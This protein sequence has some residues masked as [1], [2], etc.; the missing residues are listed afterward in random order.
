[1]ILNLIILITGIVLLIKIFV[2]LS[3]YLLF[4]LTL[5]VYI[6]YQVFLP[7]QRENVIKVLK[8]F[9]LPV[10]I[11]FFPFVVIF[12]MRDKHPKYALWGSLLWSLTYLIFAIDIMA[13]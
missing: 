1:M 12:N 8:V 2:P 5:P 11:I 3:K 6:V 7:E 10:F 9:A 4:G 13:H